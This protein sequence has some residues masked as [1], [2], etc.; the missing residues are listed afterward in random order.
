MLGCCCCFCSLCWVCAKTL[1]VD[2]IDND[3]DNNNDDNVS[4]ISKQTEEHT[5]EVC[6]VFTLFA[7]SLIVLRIYI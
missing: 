2:G 3:D 6:I 1:C 7:D 5:D 4:T